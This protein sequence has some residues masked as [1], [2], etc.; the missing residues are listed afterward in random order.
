MS[1]TSTKKAL[2]KSQAWDTPA[3]EKPNTRRKLKEAS[4][5]GA[6]LQATASSPVGNSAVAKR[7]PG[8]PPKKA[9]N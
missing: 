5:I 8:C 9:K 4:M 2:S 3:S 7:K 1:A 6:M